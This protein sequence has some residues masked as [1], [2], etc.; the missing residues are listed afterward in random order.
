MHFPEKLSEGEDL[1]CFKICLSPV[2]ER[3]TRAGQGKA[4]IS[5]GSCGCPRPV[6]PVQRPQSLKTLSCLEG[7]RKGTRELG[8]W[9]G[10]KEGRRRESMKRESRKKER[11]ESK[12]G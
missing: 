9:R 8:N 7:K 3:W 1:I 11:R 6:T 10:G 2:S 4:L 12:G 5:E